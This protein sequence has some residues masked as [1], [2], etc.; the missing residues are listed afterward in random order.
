MTVAVIAVCATVPPSLGVGVL[1]GVR[2]AGRRMPHMLAQLP[3]PAVQAV[4]RRAG[5]L[6]RGDT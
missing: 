6:R 5:Q 3:T 4:A 2:Y 1:L